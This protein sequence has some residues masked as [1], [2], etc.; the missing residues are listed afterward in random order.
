MIPLIRLR[1][2]L[3][4]K[5]GITVITEGRNRW[6]VT[7]ADHREVSRTKITKA[8]AKLLARVSIEVLS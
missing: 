1:I 2:G 5:N 6:I 3:N 4:P 7:Y 8:L